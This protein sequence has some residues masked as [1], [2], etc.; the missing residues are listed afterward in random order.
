MPR[1]MAS[2]V[3][4][5][6]YQRSSDESLKGLWHLEWSIMPSFVKDMFEEL[7]M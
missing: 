3:H 4:F 7:L 1:M 2:E 5:N 6:Q